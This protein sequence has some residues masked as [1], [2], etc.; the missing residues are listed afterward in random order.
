VDLNRTLRGV[1]DV[2]YQL[3]FKS[4]CAKIAREFTNLHFPEALVD[5]DPLKLP[6]VQ[7]LRAGKTDRMRADLLGKAFLVHHRVFSLEAVLAEFCR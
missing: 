5:S 7:I 4:V 6:S 3:V 1:A 2:L